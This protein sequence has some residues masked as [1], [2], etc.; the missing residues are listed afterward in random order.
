MRHYIYIIYNIIWYNNIYIWER[1]LLINK[2]T[3]TNF[4]QKVN[5]HLNQRYQDFIISSR[6]LYNQ[7]RY[8]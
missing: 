4:L 7:N 1:L 5:F 2:C 6:T 3:S 8:Y